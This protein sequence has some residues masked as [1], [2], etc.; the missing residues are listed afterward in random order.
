MSLLHVLHPHL[1]HIGSLARLHNPVCRLQPNKHLAFQGYFT[2][3]GTC[4]HVRF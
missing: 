2:I 3:S 4:L 1:T